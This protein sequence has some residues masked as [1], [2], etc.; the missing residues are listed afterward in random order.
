MANTIITKNSS[1][2]SAV[3]SAGSLTQGE[4]AV[5][6]TDKKLYTKDSGGSVVEITPTAIQGTSTSAIPSAAL[7]SGTANN[8][9]ILYGDRTWGAAPSSGI[10][11]AVPTN[12]QLY[13][14]NATWTKPSG[15]DYFTIIVVGAGGGGNGYFP[16]GGS[17]GGAAT[18]VVH[19]DQLNAT[20]S[21]VIGQGGRGY[22]ITSSNGSWVGS[23]YSGGASSFGGS[24]IVANGGTHGAVGGNYNGG[25]SSQVAGGTASVSGITTVAQYLTQGGYAQGW[26]YGTV[27]HRTK[28]DGV[29]GTYGGFYAAD[30]RISST[31]VS[32]P[33]Y[34]LPDVTIPSGNGNWNYWQISERVLPIYGHGGLGGAGW[35][36]YGGRGGHGVVIIAW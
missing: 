3:P 7:G 30:E 26:S 4:L 25:S 18:V 8:S 33:N 23:P 36:N 24:K 19:K 27:Y 29:N 15:V 1:T 13:T 28:G 17:G 12:I 31:P 9:T 10:V 21:I 35:D 6:V 20:E 14:S 34:L 32:Y 2:A 16:C 22:Y 5:N 11:S